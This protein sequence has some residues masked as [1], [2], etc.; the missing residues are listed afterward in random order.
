MLDLD[1]HGVR[2]A[3]RQPVN[4]VAD[5]E[6]RSGR[7]GASCDQ[8]QLPCGRRDLRIGG[9]R[10][11]GSLRFLV[12]ASDAFVLTPRTPPISIRWSRLVLESQTG[13]CRDVS[14]AAHAPE[15]A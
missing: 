5:P 11:G 3:V 4:H 14:W 9:R 8:A 1:R 7:G 6:V 12:V 2:T 10:D 13:G 15:R